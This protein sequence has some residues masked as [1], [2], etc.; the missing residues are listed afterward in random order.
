MPPQISTTRPEICSL[1][2]VTRPLKAGIIHPKCAPVGAPVVSVRLRAQIQSNSMVKFNGV[3]AIVSASTRTVHRQADCALMLASLG[4][5]ISGSLGGGCDYS[6][7]KPTR[8]SNKALHMPGHFRQHN[9]LQPGHAAER[10]AGPAEFQSQ[11]R[12]DEPRHHY[13]Q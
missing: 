4:N 11:L 1:T 2:C 12:G 13:Q 8:I 6:F 9:G 5:K 10:G 7:R 3:S